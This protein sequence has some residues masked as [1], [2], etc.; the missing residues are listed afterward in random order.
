MAQDF[1]LPDTR[2]AFSV[3]AGAA[4]D[5]PVILRTNSL[6][7]GLGHLEHLPAR[8]GVADD[9]DQTFPVAQ[10]D[11]DHAAVVAAAWTQPQGDDLVE[12]Q[13]AGQGR[14]IEVRMAISGKNGTHLTSRRVYRFSRAAVD[15]RAR[16]W[17]G[18]DHAHRDDVIEGKSTLM[19]SSMASLRGSIRE[20]A[21]VG[22]GVVGTMYTLT[23]SSPRWRAA[24]PQACRSGKAMVQMPW[25]GYWI[26]RA[27][28]KA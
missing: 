14:S 17:G 22:L 2:P 12:R 8:S 15:A 27:L 5:L 19:S 26:S 9:L 4:A 20:E 6:R 18:G 3:P 21:E 7:T 16:R 1:D 23:K 24:S 11:E 13:A 25:W 28:R 10:V